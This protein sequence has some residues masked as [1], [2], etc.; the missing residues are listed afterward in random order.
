MTREEI[1]K[2]R[3]DI[4]NWLA[5]A[6]EKVNSFSDSEK[7]YLQDRIE[8]FWRKS[9]KGLADAIADGIAE[10]LGMENP[11]NFCIDWKWDGFFGLN[12]VAG[13]TFDKLKI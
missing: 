7:E 1:Q 9:S 2:K 4:N 6:Q 12:F 8:A 13:E 5:R 3:E 10:F 11:L